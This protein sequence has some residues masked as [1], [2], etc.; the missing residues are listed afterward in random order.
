MISIEKWK[1]EFLDILY[2]RHCPVCHDIAVPRG[3]KICRECQKKLKPVS[4]ARCFRCSRPLEKAEQE[5]CRTCRNQ[6]Y[7]Y[8]RGMGIFT[9]GTVLQQ[10][11]I[12]L[13]YEKRQEYGVF[14]GESAAVY[15]KE[16]IQKW[17]VQV[18]IPI[19]LH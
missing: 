12:K 15:A 19:P 14:Y 11:L 9:Y 17:G 6:S 4:Q 13:K 10:S 7:H 16:Q 2:P 5:Y 1:K 18:L 8:D 3:Q